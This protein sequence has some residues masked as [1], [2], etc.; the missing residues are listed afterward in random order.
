MRAAGVMGSMTLLSRILGYLRD[1]IL[2]DLLGTGPLAD[3]FYLAFRIP[4]TF[5][6]LLGEGAMTAAFVPVFSE[7]RQKASSEELWSF[8][9][10]FFYAFALSVGAL[11]LLGMIFARQ[12]TW[13]MARRFAH[14][15]GYFDLTVRL[16]ALMF[17]YLFLV[18][19]AA[20]AMAI[21]NALDIF[22]PPAFT[23]VLLNL[24]I[25][26]AALLVP[27]T[28]LSRPF[29]L[30]LGVLVGGVMQ[31]VFQLPYLKREGMRFLPPAISFTHPGVR[32]CLRLFAPG[33]LGAG[34]YQITVL[35]GTA[36]AAN[37]GEGAISSLYYANRVTELA[38]GIFIV[39]ISQV[40]LPLMSRQAAEED[41][42]ALRETLTFSFGLVS[43]L[44]IPATVG[45]SL[46]AEPIIRV[47]FLTGR[48]DQAS[49]VQTSAPLIAYAV[50]LL[51][52]G[53]VRVLLSAFY[54]RKDTRSPAVLSAIVLAVFYGTSRL[55]IPHFGHV[56]IAIG[57]TIGTVCH[58]L[59]LTAWF[60]N[61]W[62][63]PTALVPLLR[64]VGKTLLCSAG[65]GGLLWL[66]RDVLP[67][68]R[69]PWIAQAGMLAAT[70]GISGLCYLLLARLLR[71][72]EMTTLLSM[73][74]RKLG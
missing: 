42:T 48:F 1:R 35:V 40:I 51:P 73:I 43:F 69:A 59:L 12:I 26:A 58:F 24:S 22:G 20:L 45:L 46:L 41:E 30:A 39:S 23:P 56:G 15:P 3:A 36:M 4:N 57:S 10:R 64:S 52:M 62:G 74:R 66:G 70:I 34:I 67:W 8:V 7:Y 44:M 50:G 5:R 21:L 61:K 14:D 19:L 72:E 6:R 71:C 27:E 25:I 38:F 16:T 28:L 54:A 60:T 33:I 47:L 11:T 13:V 53:W 63:R 49:V 29:A 2:A 32:K 31:C 55:L 68:E 65:M 17:P 9:R 37:V 18:C